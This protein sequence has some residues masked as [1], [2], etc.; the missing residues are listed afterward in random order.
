MA[1]AYILVII[2]YKFGHYQKLGPIILLEIDK[3]SRICI[4]Y[5]IFPFY[6]VVNLWVKSR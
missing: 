5:T 4:Y 6:L 3:S 2:I 1:D